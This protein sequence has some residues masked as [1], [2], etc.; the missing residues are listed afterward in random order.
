MSPTVRIRSYF[1]PLVDMPLIMKK[2]GSV[3]L[4]SCITL[5]CVCVNQ[6]ICNALRFIRWI[7][8]GKHQIASEIRISTEMNCSVTKTSVEC[9]TMNL[10]N[11]A[12]QKCNI[13]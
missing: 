3:G 6:I 5:I 4:V 12:S 13:S 10:H 9:D 1:I 7:S 11:P 2:E 8:V